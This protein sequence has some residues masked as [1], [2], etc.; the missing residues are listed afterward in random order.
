M[1]KVNNIKNLLEN[2]K[3]IVEKNLDKLQVEANL[4]ELNQI[5]AHITLNKSFSNKN[6]VIVDLINIPFILINLFKQ[7]NLELFIQYINYVEK[8]EEQKKSKII[9]IIKH[10]VSV[11][12]FVA[13][14][15][16]LN[17]LRMGHHIYDS[18]MV[19]EII[20]IPFYD[21]ISNII[22]DQNRSQLIALNIN[23]YTYELFRQDHKSLSKGNEP[24]DYV[25]NLVKNVEKHFNEIVLL[26][27]E[28]NEMSCD[29]KENMLI[30]I[31][32]NHLVRSL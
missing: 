12:K 4:K 22:G 30:S 9:E 20:N 31:L 24:K 27:R 16:F 21:C 28:I 15:Y 6:Q 5:F 29:C 1:K 2:N 18:L 14:R 23:L 7:N 26:I 17:N 19:N 11:I 13:K 3:I 32:D 25:N 10:T 8:I